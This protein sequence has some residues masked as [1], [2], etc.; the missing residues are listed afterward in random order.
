[1]HI[2]CIGEGPVVHITPNEL[3]WG[4][5][6]VLTN[7]PKVITLSNES[8]IPA[9]FTANMVSTSWYPYFGYTSVP[10]QLKLIK[11]WYACV[12]VCILNLSNFCLFVICD[13]VA[14][15]E[16]PVSFQCWPG[17]RGNSRR[18]VTGHQGHCPPR[19]RG[20]IPGQTTAEFPGESSSLHPPHWIRPGHHHSVRPSPH[21]AARPGTKLQVG[22]SINMCWIFSSVVYTGTKVHV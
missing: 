18:E 10:T 20:Q 8:L 17:G 7:V 13:M 5:V 1:M 2:S 9:R 21:P 3:D 22:L 11:D 6:P 19:W 14:V 12:C 16:T 4:V 15:G